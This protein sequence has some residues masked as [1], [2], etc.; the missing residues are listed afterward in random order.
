LATDLDFSFYF[1]WEACRTEEGFY[2]V[3]GSVDYCVKRALAFSEYCDM[4][5]METDSPKLDVAKE[6]SDKVHA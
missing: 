5:W 3:V 1:N 2:R 4:I 6:F